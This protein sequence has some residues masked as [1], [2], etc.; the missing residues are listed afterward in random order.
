MDAHRGYR[1]TCETLMMCQD[2]AHREE[3]D[4]ARGPMESSP[5]ARSRGEKKKIAMPRG[6]AW[7]KPA[8]GLTGRRPAWRARGLGAAGARGRSRGG[9]SSRNPLSQTGHAEAVPSVQ[10]ERFSLYIPS[11]SLYPSLS[12]TIKT[13]SIA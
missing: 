8:W 9:R 13:I 1:D 3:A 12:T 4:G 11:V 2:K 10:R 6:A 7:G 5:G